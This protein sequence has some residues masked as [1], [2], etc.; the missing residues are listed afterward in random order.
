MLSF[1]NEGKTCPQKVLFNSDV[2]II[3]LK[4]GDWM[5]KKLSNV[6]TPEESAIITNKIREK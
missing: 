6:N 1:L 5:E 2:K 4:N 3:N